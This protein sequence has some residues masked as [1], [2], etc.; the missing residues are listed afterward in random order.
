MGSVLPGDSIQGNEQMFVYLEGIMEAATEKT[1]GERI[2]VEVC[3]LLE[4]VPSEDYY[5]DMFKSLVVI[6][7]NVAEPERLEER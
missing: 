7:R 2:I 1:E 5:A 6:L 4:T 3:A